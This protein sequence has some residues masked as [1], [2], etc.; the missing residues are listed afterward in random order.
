M[1]GYRSGGGILQ[2]YQ[3]FSAL[4]LF[5]LKDSQTRIESIHGRLNT[6][7][8]IYAYLRAKIPEM[9]E[10]DKSVSGDGIKP[11]QIIMDEID[12][13]IIQCR[14]TYQSAFEEERTYTDEENKFLQLLD[15]ILYRE[16]EIIA[17]T[18]FIDNE[19]MTEFE[20][21]AGTT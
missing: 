16:T 6:L 15:G 13:L 7:V 8:H 20:V 4:T 12:G 21:P 11:L 17:R 2:N 1:P 9:K 3:G 10:A 14:R 18:K 19:R 5:A